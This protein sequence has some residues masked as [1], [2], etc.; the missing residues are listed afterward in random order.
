M[1]RRKKKEK[2][3]KK[4]VGENNGQLR[5]QARLD[6]KSTVIIIQLSIPKV[7]TTVGAGKPSGPYRNPCLNIV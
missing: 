2:K 5:T 1:L 4:K 7:N 3:K 6:Q